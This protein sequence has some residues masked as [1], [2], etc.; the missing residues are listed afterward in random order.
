MPISHL[1]VT[2]SDAPQDSR[3][4]SRDT[5]LTCAGCGAN[6]RQVAHWVLPGLCNECAIRVESVTVSARPQ[7][8]GALFDTSRRPA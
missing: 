2:L 6:N 1:I 3:D 8:Q 5:K 7:S 4:L